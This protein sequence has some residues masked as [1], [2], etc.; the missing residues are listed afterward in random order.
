MEALKFIIR[1]GDPLY[2]D[3]GQVG[4]AGTAIAVYVQPMDEYDPAKNAANIA[5]ALQLAQ[6]SG[7]RL[8][9]QTHKMLGIA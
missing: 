9:L 4:Q 2:G 6:E 3:V 8:S 5:R 7:Y 1:A